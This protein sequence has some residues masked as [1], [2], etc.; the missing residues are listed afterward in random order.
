MLPGKPPYSQQGGA[1]P[2]S[3]ISGM[4]FSYPCGEKTNRQAPLGAWRF[5]WSHLS[6][7]L[8]SSFYETFQNGGKYSL[9]NTRLDTEYWLRILDNYYF[10]LENN[11]M[12][13]PESY[14]LFPERLKIS[15]KEGLVYINCK[16]CDTKCTEQSL[17]L[18]VCP[19]CS[20]IIREE[21][22]AKRKIIDIKR[23]AEEVQRNATHIKGNH[24]SPKI[25]Y[26]P[27]THQQPSIQPKKT[28]L[29]DV[30]SSIFS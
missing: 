19:D 21:N 9:E 28:S 11:K 18:G 4:N 5:I 1:D 17:R 20:R 13:D 16:K 26:S 25:S 23:Q 27:R 30:I 8:K 10:S 15:E 6:F 29:W 7:A 24:A 22:E 3:N 12:T 2:M 14:V